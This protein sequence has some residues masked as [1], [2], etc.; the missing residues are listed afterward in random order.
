MPSITSP[1]T[2]TIAGTSS[3][4]R[5]GNITAD[6][7]C[8]RPAKEARNGQ[9]QQTKHRLRYAMRHWRHRTVFLW[10]KVS[11][12]PLYGL[13][14]GTY[15]YES[16]EG[17]LPKGW[18]FNADSRFEFVEIGPEE[19]YD[20]NKILENG[21]WGMQK[22]TFDENGNKVYNGNCKMVWS[23]TPFD[24][25][26]PLKFAGA[27]SAR[28]NAALVGMC[29]QC[30]ENSDC[31]WRD[32]FGNTASCRITPLT[33]SDYSKRRIS[34]WLRQANEMADAFSVTFSM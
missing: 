28:D 18:S 33:K 10:K 30:H 2:F 20:K 7:D 21:S 9:N 23:N 29:H 27:H 31:V 3:T 25:L 8:S 4:A 11:D 13:I 32:Y 12:T 22:F 14:E 17:I 34:I 5:P 6:V 19:A 15:Y 1:G 26:P 16:Q 24:S